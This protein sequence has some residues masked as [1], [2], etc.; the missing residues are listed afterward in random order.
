V[1]AYSV[2]GDETLERRRYREA[3]AAK[4]ARKRVR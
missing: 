1:L 4:P 2:V 3:G